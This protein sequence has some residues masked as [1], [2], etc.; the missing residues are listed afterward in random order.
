MKENQNKGVKF[1]GWEALD[2]EINEQKPLA[3]LV[4]KNK[5][6]AVLKVDTTNMYGAFYMKDLPPQQDFEVELFTWEKLDL[7]EEIKARFNLN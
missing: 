7:V 1:P 3:V 5:E 4:I 6:G 2:A